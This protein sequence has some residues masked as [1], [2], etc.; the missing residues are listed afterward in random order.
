M[1]SRPAARLRWGVACR[2]GC[3]ICEERSS[4]KIP[5]PSEAACNRVPGKLKR[6]SDPAPIALSGTAT[7]QY[8]PDG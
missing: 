7:E 6:K 1:T 3:A 8:P 5:D 2:R 4:L